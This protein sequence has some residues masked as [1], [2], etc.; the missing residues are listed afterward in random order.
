MRDEGEEAGGVRGAEF[1]LVP[2]VSEWNCE[3]KVGWIKS[4][5]LGRWV[6]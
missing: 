4:Y 5:S 6:E 1:V 3:L 2:G